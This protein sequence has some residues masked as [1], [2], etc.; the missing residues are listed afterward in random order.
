MKNSNNGFMR[1]GRRSRRTLLIDTIQYSGRGK[2]KI[3][4]GY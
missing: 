3:I 4:S 1:A 2:Q